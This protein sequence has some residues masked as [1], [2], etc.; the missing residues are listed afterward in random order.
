MVKI[1]FFIILFIMIYVFWKIYLQ[2]DSNQ[3]IKNRLTKTKEIKTE[4]VVYSDSKTEYVID[5]V[6]PYEQQLFDDIS[7]IFIAHKI[8][9]RDKD[10]ASQLQEE[11][12]RRMPLKTKTTIR[13]CELD[14]WAVYWGFYDQ[15][16]EYYVGKYGV[17]IT[18]VDRDGNEHKITHT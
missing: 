6:E 5:E 3:K 16:L 4:S 12:L 2:I 13:Q 1:L 18:H 10:K 11:V 7:E 17:F 9:N 14:E 15:S 8:K